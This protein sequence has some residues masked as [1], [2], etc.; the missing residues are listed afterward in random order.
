M[1]K[2]MVCTYILLI[3]LGNYLAYGQTTYPEN[4]NEFSN[5]IIL[6]KFVMNNQIIGKRDFKLNGYSYKMK[7]T[8]DGDALKFEIKRIKPKLLYVYVVKGFET[9]LWSDNIDFMRFDSEK[10][11]LFIYSIK[12]KLNINVRKWTYH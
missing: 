11:E 1:K 9:I 5:I 7:V 3:C 2:I 6:T 12:N 8:E 4:I 10:K